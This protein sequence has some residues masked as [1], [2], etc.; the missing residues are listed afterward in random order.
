MVTMCKNI[1]P[2]SY[3][4]ASIS[5]QGVQLSL[6]E[7]QKRHKAHTSDRFL[8]VLMIEDDIRNCVL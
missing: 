1:C 2:D 4:K 3:C 6:G 7:V 5:K 8:S